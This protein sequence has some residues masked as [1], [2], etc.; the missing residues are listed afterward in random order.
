MGL[1]K[2]IFSK[3][4]IHLLSLIICYVASIAT[5]LRWFKLGNALFRVKPRPTPPAILQDEKWG[6]HGY[7]NL[8][9]Q[10]IKI[11]YVENGDRS[12]PLMVCFHG[13]PEFWFS[14]RYQ[15]EEFST[16][17]WVVAV[18]L[19]GYGDSD[20]P[21]SL[22]D[23][24]IDKLV[25]DLRQIILELGRMKEIDWNKERCTVMAHDWG[26]ALAWLLVNLHPQLFDYHISCNGPHPIAGAR[27][28]QSSFK[29][30]FMSWYMIFFQTRWI[31]EMIIRTND[32][33]MFDNLAKPMKN[34]DE[35]FNHEIIEA[36]KYTFGKKGALTGPV[37]YYR[38]MDPTMAEKSFPKVSVPTL[39]VWGTEDQALAKP[40][41]EL[42][43]ALCENAQIQWVENTGHWV[44]MEEHALVNNLI[45]D[46]FVKNKKIVETQDESVTSA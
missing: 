14:W 33:E 19:R 32:L 22:S 35:M 17:H 40:I 45:R 15:L 27:H 43:A 42:S 30:K 16:D 20:K 18:D 13:F 12:K 36:Y 11:H 5:L 44:Q 10:G 41:A 37:N 29:Q 25:E 38:N 7:L 34:R 9:S 46:Y 28:R 4:I 8:K 39:I 23:Y 24:S 3:V 6:T 26:G 2:K 21:S 31:P 1:V